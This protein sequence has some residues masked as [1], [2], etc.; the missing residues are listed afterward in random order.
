MIL[1]DKTRKEFTT[2]LSNVTHCDGSA[3]VQTIDA[4][5]NERFYKLVEAFATLSGIAVLLNTSLNRKGFPIVEIP[6]EALQLFDETALDVLVL[7]DV[8][9]EKI[10]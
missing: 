3:R 10:S 2:Q 4:N 5:W 1:V 9:L 7:E 8:M 6:M